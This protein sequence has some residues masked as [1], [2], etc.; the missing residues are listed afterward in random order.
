MGEKNESKKVL[1]EAIRFETDGREFF[2]KAAEKAKTYFAK[3][4]FQTIAEE[5]LDH[6]RRVKQIYESDAVSKKQKGSPVVS[7]KRNLQNIFQEA[8]EQM[9]QSITM[10]ADEMEAVRLAIQ[11]EFKGHEFYTR[12]A[13][14]ALGDFEKTFYQHLAQEE[15]VH[16]STLRQME[17]AVT[18]PTRLG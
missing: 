4:I 13:Q 14:E 5:E 2:L 6:I 17:E 18:N 1:E 10:N 15:L 8:K 9:G 7:E 3:V 12:L 11:L 16:F